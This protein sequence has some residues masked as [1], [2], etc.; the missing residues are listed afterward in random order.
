L[1]SKR[2][3][4][5][6]ETPKEGSGNASHRTTAPQQSVT[7]S[8][9]AQVEKSGQFSKFNSHGMAFSIVL[10]EVATSHHCSGKPISAR[11]AGRILQDPS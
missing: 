5:R 3:K 9:K 4:S 10:N 8:H 7:A 6:E 2:P 11:A 1:R